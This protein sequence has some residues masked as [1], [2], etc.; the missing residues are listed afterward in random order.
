MVQCICS[1][2]LPEYSEEGGGKVL[3]RTHNILLEFGE[4]DL[5][6]FFLEFDSPVHPLEIIGFWKKF[7][8]VADALYKL[9]YLNFQ[10][11]DGQQEPLHGFVLRAVN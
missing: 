11:R 5:D 1:Y 2:S 6:E 4:F 10:N 8:K 9:H 3:T 7:F